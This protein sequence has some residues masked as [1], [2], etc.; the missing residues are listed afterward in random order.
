[1]ALLL[2]ENYLEWSRNDGQLRQIKKALKT[3]KLLPFVF[4]VFEVSSKPGI[5]ATSGILAKTQEML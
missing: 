4:R 5:R 3:I 1:M 2:Y